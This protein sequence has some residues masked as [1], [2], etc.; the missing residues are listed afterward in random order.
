M[1]KECCA[2]RGDV[3]ILTCSGGS[4]V[5]Q[6][7]NQAAVGG[8]TLSEKAPGSLPSRCAC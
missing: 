3:M 2:S 1:E 5:G 4:N 7:A 6:V 8:E